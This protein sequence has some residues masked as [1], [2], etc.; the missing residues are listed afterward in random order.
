MT[1]RITTPSDRFAWR[2]ASQRSPLFIFAVTGVHMHYVC[3]VVNVKF[4]HTINK[5]AENGFLFFAQTRRI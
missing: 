3:I 2:R 4:L 1:I 5:G